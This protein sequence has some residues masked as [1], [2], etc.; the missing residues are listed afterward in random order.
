MN[1]V[2]YSQSQTEDGRSVVKVVD[3]FVVGC[4]VHLYMPG[5][6]RLCIRLGS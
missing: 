3:H 6:Q 4:V 5:R 1:V 2:S